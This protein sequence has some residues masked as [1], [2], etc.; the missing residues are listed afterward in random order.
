MEGGTCVKAV[1]TKIN[2]VEDKVKKM[3]PVLM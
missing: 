1:L 3:L 2:S